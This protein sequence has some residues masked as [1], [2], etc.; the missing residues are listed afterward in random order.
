MT[1]YIVNGSPRNNFNTKQ[2]LEKSIEGIKSIK[3]DAEIEEINLYQLNYTGCRGCF[4]CKV[5]NGPFYSKCP[6][7]DDL[8]ELLSK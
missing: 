4:S 8:K 3:K 5:K 6:I 2:L 1:Y 7:N